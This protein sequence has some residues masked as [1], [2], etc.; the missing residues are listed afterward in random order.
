MKTKL[1]LVF[2]LIPFFSFSQTQ[3]GNQ[4]NNPDENS[5]KPSRFGNAVAISDDGTI[6]AIGAPGHNENSFVRIFKYENATWNQLGT[7]IVNEAI[8][9]KIGT[10]V[11]LSSDGKT[12]AIG[13]V[14]GGNLDEG[15]VRFY[16]FKNDSWQ[17][18]GNE[19]IGAG[20]QH[21]IGYKV[22]MTPD[23]KFVAV[24]T[25]DNKADKGYVKVYENISGSWTQKGT[26][27][28][29]EFTSDHFGI[30]I[31][32]SDDGNTLA[33]GN[34]GRR[35]AMV[36]EFKNNDWSQ[37]GNEFTDLVSDN[38]ANISVSLSADG[39]K[40]AIGAKSGVSI[41][42]NTAGTWNLLGSLINFGSSSSLSS[43]G[44]KIAIASP[45]DYTVRNYIF[46]NN[47][48]TQRGVD[49][50]TWR[51]SNFGEAIALSADGETFIA[52]SE[53]AFPRV[54]SFKSTLNIK[55]YKLNEFTNIYPNPVKDN[56]TISFSNENSLKKAVIYNQQGKKILESK[57]K[58]INIST[59]STGIYFLELETEK[60][61]ITK[62]LIKK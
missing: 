46:E 54:Y 40:V 28:E 53:N 6:V 41:Y 13:A 19:I 42:E 58:E 31:D 14:A 48:W 45:Y 32:L 22:V 33:I 34:R 18:L 44:T 30:T 61:K 55:K 2:F 35:K 7:D 11:S 26:I 39:K 60:G 10:S 29:G 56:F 37:I 20:I 25:I 23:T 27:L 52:G 1:L 5:I 51:S 57:N 36:Y 59:F 12:V 38:R 16:E 43:D 4:F 3:L 49:V 9:E 50:K 24:S 17:K 15:S 62:K 8:L 47:I 21:S